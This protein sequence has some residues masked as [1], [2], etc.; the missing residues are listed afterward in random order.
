MQLSSFETYSAN[1]LHQSPQDAELHLYLQHVAGAARAL[2][3]SALERV[4]QH[5]GLPLAQLRL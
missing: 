2:F 1:C 4:A 3:E 5:E